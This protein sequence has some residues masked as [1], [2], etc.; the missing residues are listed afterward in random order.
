MATPRKTT[1]LEDKTETVETAVETISA[2]YTKSVERLAQ[3]QKKTL[4]IA[5]QQNAEMI[6]AWK[7]IAQAAPG[8]PVPNILDLAGN[9]FGQFVD[10]Q[11]GAIDLAL[12]QTQSLA[13]LAS[14]RAD[15][16]SSA[17]ESV[18]TMVHDTVE[19]VAANQKNAIEFSAAQ[20]KAV[21]DSFKKQ[22]GVAGTPV[23]V[24]VDSIQRGFD[25][26]VETQKEILH[27]ASRRTA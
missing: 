4:D 16:V 25:S 22:P 15:Y 18:K 9:M 3:A 7:K 23:E 2:L 27:I 17:S 5:L 11:K 8:V 12:E 20:T 10:L 19:R 1:N 26:L 24:T 14:E 13:G 21:I 6:G